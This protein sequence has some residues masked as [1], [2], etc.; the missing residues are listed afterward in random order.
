MFRLMR[1]THLALG[2]LFVVM[3]AIFALSSLR[4]IYRPWLPTTPEDTERI[5]TLAMEGDAGPR[6]VALALMRDHG[7]KGDLRA[8]E[9]G[10]GEIR[11]RI[12]RPGEEARVAYCLDSGQA[13]ISTRRWGLQET[14]VQLHVNHG[15]HHDFWP[16]QAWAAI[17][18]LTSLGMLFLGGTGIYLWFAHHKER[19]IGGVL[20]A[21]GLSW[22][23]ANLTIARML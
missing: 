16:S 5:V 15:F 9:E 1:N 22:G 21:F 4:F 7:L 20:L 11:F 2:L 3:A 14:L 23:I 12:F 19:V 8:I 6:D 10:D 18:F 17:S 13:V